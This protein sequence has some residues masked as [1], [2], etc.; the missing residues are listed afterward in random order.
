MCIDIYWMDFS[1]FID[2]RVWRQAYCIQLRNPFIFVFVS[3]FM[4]WFIALFHFPPTNK[5]KKETKNKSRKNKLFQQNIIKRLLHF[6][7]FS[8]VFRISNADTFTYIHIYFEKNTCN[9]ITKSDEWTLY[10]FRM[11]FSHVC[12]YASTTFH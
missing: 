6:S 9:F 1:Y 5:T 7:H 10:I 4:K 12:T 2:A 8:H 3:S 11:S